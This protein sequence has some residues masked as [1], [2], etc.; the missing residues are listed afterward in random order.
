MLSTSSPLGAKSLVY[1]QLDDG[2]SHAV[3]DDMKQGRLWTLDVVGGRGASPTAGPSHEG[4][5]HLDRRALAPL[6]SGPHLP[7][8]RSGPT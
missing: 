7:T 6:S 3:D 5:G 4:R 2:A 8:P 1:F